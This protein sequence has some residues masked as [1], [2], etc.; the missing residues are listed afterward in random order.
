MIEDRL[1]V[2][3]FKGG[4]RDALRAIYEKYGDAEKPVFWYRPEGSQDYHVIYGDLS[5][6]EVAPDD[7]PN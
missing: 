7:L 4:S 3:K 1:L 6:K 2:W 5:V